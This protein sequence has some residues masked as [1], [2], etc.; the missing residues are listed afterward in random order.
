VSK[1]LKNSLAGLVLILGL[2]L[3]AASPAQ[4]PQRKLSHLTPPPAASQKSY[5][6]LREQNGMGKRGIIDSAH[7]YEEIRMQFSIDWTDCKIH[8]TDDC[9]PIQIILP[10]TVNG[11]VPL[12]WNLKASQPQTSGMPILYLIENI[13]GQP[14]QAGD[15]NIP[16]TWEI[17]LDGGQFNPMTLMPDNT[18]TTT[19]PP[20]P[21]TFQVRITG[22]PQYHQA[23]GYYRLQLTQSLVPQL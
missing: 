17:S 12:F 10:G 20:G 18:L 21:H 23:D 13:F 22:T 15:T 14:A 7:P 3:A 4:T 9:S 16:L 2:C 11:S 19:F 6:I 8:R 1:T 5:Y